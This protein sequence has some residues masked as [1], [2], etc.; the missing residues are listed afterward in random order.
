M[1]NQSNTIGSDHTGEQLRKSG[2]WEYIEILVR[3]R[4]FIIINFIVITTVSVIVSFLLPQWYKATATLLPPKRQD[5][6]GTFGTTSSVLRSLTGGGLRGLGQSSQAYN[7]FAILKSRTASEAV[8]RKFNLIEVYDISD[9][10]MEKAIKELASNVSFEEEADD[11]ISI[12]VLDKD[13]QRA[14]DIAN[15]YVELLNQISTKLGTTEA[16]NNREFVEARLAQ[17]KTA[18]AI[19]EDSLR[20]YQ[21]KSGIMISPEQTETISSIASLYGMKAKKEVELAVLEHTMGS[22][23]QLVKQARLELNELDRKLATFPEVGLESFR[24]YRDVAIQQKI[25]EFLVPIYE[26]ARID[27]QKDVPVVLVLDKAIRPERK[28]KP[29]R[30]LIVVLVSSLSLCFLLVSA[31]LLHGL[32]QKQL[33]QTQLEAAIRVWS[34]KVHRLYRI[35]E[36]SKPSS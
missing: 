15:Y 23:N 1:S 34:T 30:T 3:W 33:N 11:Y 21:E 28:Y 5:I 35:K 14:A 6:F 29:Q 13:P 9:T 17:A 24:R 2:L 12:E 22:D 4:R 18:L 26:Q 16:R 19:A 8:V 36:I 27:E 31:F 32:E 25:V 7:Y 10:S 20:S